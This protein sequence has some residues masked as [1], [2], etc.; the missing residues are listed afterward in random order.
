MIILW[1]EKKPKLMLSKRRHAGYRL[2]IAWCSMH[3]RMLEP[4]KFETKSL[5][6][7][8][9]LAWTWRLLAGSCSWWRAWRTSGKA[10]K[11]GAFLSLRAFWFSWLWKLCYHLPVYH[12]PPLSVTT[13][14]PMT[15]MTPMV[16]RWWDHWGWGPKVSSFIFLWVMQS[17]I[18]EFK[19]CSC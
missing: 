9:S 6:V 10:R 12:A 16:L 5:R 19:A 2:E 3:G 15:P 14:S 4:R 1:C 8:Q 11:N 13:E 18:F 17:M 7:I